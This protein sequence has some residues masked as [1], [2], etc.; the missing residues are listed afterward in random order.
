VVH[1]W[2][3]GCLLVDSFNYQSCLPLFTNFK[4]AYH[5][6]ENIKNIRTN[7]IN[8]NKKQNQGKIKAIQDKAIQAFLH[9]AIILPVVMFYLKILHQFLYRCLDNRTNV[10]NLFY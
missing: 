10:S 8:K 6:F 5:F 1:C 4:I 7:L 3:F 9:W 2:L